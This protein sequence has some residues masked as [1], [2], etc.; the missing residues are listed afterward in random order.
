MQLLLCF[1]FMLARLSLVKLSIGSDHRSQKSAK[2]SLVPRRFRFGQW[3][4]VGGVGGQGKGGG[5]R[6]RA[7]PRF[8]AENTFTDVFDNTRDISDFKK[9]NEAGPPE[10]LPTGVLS[11]IDY[12]HARHCIDCLCQ[13]TTQMA[14]WKIW[15]GV[16]V[17]LS[18]R[19]APPPAPHGSKRSAASGI[20][21]PL[22]EKSNIMHSLLILITYLLRNLLKFGS[23][24]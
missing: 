9:H 2:H 23:I 7:S 12:G 14:F 15:G 17:C 16:C 10:Q 18:G 21:C 22:T 3:F 20:I 6:C 1:I 5:G 11:R 4:I 24:W 13:R 19:W 8:G